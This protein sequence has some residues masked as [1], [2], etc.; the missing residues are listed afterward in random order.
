MKDQETSVV[1][2][3][4]HASSYDKQFAK[5]AP[6]RDA[7]NLL[8]RMVLSELPADARILCIG[9]GTGKELID[10]AQAFPQWRFTAV[11]T[12]APMLDICRQRAEECGVA[13]RC[14][15]HE[16]YLDSLPKS[17]SYNAATSLLVSHFLKQIEERRNYFRQIAARLCPGGYL[18]NADIASDMSTSAHKNLFEVWMQA[19]K[20]AEMPAE[21]VEK[22]RAS[23]GQDVA[24][25]PPR[26]VESIIAS[27]GFDTPVLFLQS[28]FIHAWY[29]ERVS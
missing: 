22:F 9:V 12:A 14:T 13:A 19:L 15:F 18:V 21:Q 24:V 29:S 8:I 2:D 11:E 7:L 26:E 23:F 4:I 27:S 25:L 16:G 28:L 3:P 17:D 1:F 6:V 5:L 10:L 20:Y